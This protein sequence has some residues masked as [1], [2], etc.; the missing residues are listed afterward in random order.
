MKMRLSVARRTLAWHN[1]GRTCK[2]AR[3]SAVGA[4]YGLLRAQLQED[5]RAVHGD[6]TN[7]KRQFGQWEGASE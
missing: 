7:W 2:G 5:S 3:D 6:D 4:I 1:S